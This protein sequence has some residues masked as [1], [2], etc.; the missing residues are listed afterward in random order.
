MFAG[1]GALSTS[2]LRN[3]PKAQAERLARPLICQTSFTLLMRYEEQVA[4]SIRRR[5]TVRRM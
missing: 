1:H 4:A 3:P 2:G 5:W